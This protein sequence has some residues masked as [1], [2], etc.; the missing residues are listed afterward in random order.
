MKLVR[1]IS[2]KTKSLLLQE[3][4]LFS[5]CV[6]KEIWSHLPTFCLI[7]LHLWRL[8]LCYISEPIF[9]SFHFPLNPLIA[10]ALVIFKSF[11][12]FF[13]LISHSKFN[14]L[15]SNTSALRNSI[16]IRIWVKRFEVL[17]FFPFFLFFF[18]F[19]VKGILLA[20]FL[21]RGIFL[22]CEDKENVSPSEQLVW[23]SLSKLLR[24]GFDKAT[25]GWDQDIRV[26]G[27]I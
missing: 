10:Q 1:H 17:K 11:R 13:A 24:R 15:W 23:E 25:R 12:F 7:F 20:K 26:T 16:Q 8:K 19:K 22:T 14:T 4:N 9:F 21:P 6:N 5:Y 18:F 3:L 27:R 2:I